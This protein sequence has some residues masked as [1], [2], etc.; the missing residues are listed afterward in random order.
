MNTKKN[1][2]EQLELALDSFG[3]II[4]SGE[5]IRTPAGL[6]KKLRLYVIDNSIVDVFLSPSGRYSYH[7]ER[8]HLDDTIYRH[9][10]APHQKWDNLETY[11]KH[12]HHGSEKKEDIRNSYIS[13]TPVKAIEEFLNFV[14]REISDS[15]DK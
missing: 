1:Y 5:I 13:D 8:R 6:P 12:F 14:E 4:E 3:H 11:P 15:F 9:D 7:W 10:N 2:R